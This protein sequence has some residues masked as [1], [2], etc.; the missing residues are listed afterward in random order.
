[1]HT[2]QDYRIAEL[3]AERDRLRAVLA[4]A[5]WTL[6]DIWNKVLK[7]EHAYGCPEDDT[8]SCGNVARIN[9]ALEGIDVHWRNGDR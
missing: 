2:E 7:I 1:M 5:Q 4:F 6:Y 9:K 8:C 3:E